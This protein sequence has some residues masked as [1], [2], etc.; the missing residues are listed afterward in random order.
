MVRDLRFG[1]FWWVFGWVSVAIALYLNLAPVTALEL[2]D[3]NDKFEHCLGYFL[4]TFWFCSIYPR[5]QYWQVGMAMLGM[6]IL[7][8]VLQGAMQLGRHADLLD[9]GA[10]IIGI[11]PALLLA[12]TPLSRWPYW[13]EA[14]VPGA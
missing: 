7:V 14:L 2:P 5:R 9:V 4:L 12:L 3:W 8:E 10:D 11:T 13:L 6:G 1:K